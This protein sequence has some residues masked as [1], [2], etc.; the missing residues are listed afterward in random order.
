MS[1][2]V[3]DPVSF[4]ARQ[5]RGFLGVSLADQIQWPDSGTALKSWRTAFY[6]AGVTVFKDAFRARGYAGFSLFDEEFPVI[7]LNNSNAKA[8][9]ISTLFYELA[10]LL[11][12]TSGIDKDVPFRQPFPADMHRIET[13]CDCLASAILLPEEPLSREISTCPADKTL[14]E[15]L[16]QKFS[17]SKVMVFRRFRYLGLVTDAAFDDAL[18]KWDSQIVNDKGGVGGNYYHTKI[19]YLGKEYTTLAFKRFYQDRIDEE[20]LA[21][22]LAIKP[23]HLDKLEDTLHEVSR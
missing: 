12:H 10:H 15:N 2:S 3:D 7:Y 19:A 17:V 4:T 9:Q 11:F 21:D 13:I 8:K 22:Y 18:H 23:K 16:A 14:A 1:F 20:E 5:V 6:D